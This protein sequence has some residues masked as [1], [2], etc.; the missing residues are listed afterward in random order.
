MANSV[1]I[2]EPLFYGKNEFALHKR[3]TK[4]EDFIQRVEHFQRTATPVWT[5][6][7]AAGHAISYLRD[8]AASWFNDSL[9]S[10]S[11]ATW[12]DAGASFL[13]FKTVFI[14][15]FFEVKSVND[16]G[17]DWHNLR[18]TDHESVREFALRTFATLSKYESYLGVQPA[19][20]VLLEA[21]R[22]A[23]LAVRAANPDAALLAEQAR[24]SAAI[25]T[26]SAER[27]TSRVIHDFGRKIVADGVKSPKIRE[28]I[29]KEMRTGVDSM[30][31]IDH[32]EQLEQAGLKKAPTSNNKAVSSMPTIK[33]PIAAVEEDSE[34][35]DDGVNEVSNGTKKKKQ[36][37]NK[38]KFPKAGDKPNGGGGGGGNGRQET[39]QQQ[40][41]SQPNQGGQGDK[42][43][44]WKKFPC[45]LCDQT[46]HSAHQC[47]RLS[48]FRSSQGLGPVAQ[49]DLDAQG[50]GDFG[51]G[52]GRPTLRYDSGHIGEV[53]AVYKKRSG[54]ADG[55]M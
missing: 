53:Q 51:G 33:T 6:Q 9:K 43:Q 23:N 21:L 24:A 8:G 28:L 18:Q 15:N 38:K 19:D 35:E 42:K 22:V 25:H 30:A 13:A 10:L 11:K 5:D 29:L 48:N 40:P 4:A 32:M 7:I 41:R 27:H 52:Y 54:N 55:W 16:L 26:D 45:P 1:I 34:E 50:Q 44:T 36:N 31:L 46:G 14:R 39:Q 20:P 12:T 17:V 2:Q 49:H 3:G 47:N 37:K